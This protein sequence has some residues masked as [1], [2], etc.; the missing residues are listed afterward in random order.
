[1]EDKHRRLLDD[2][3][4][5]LGVERAM[6]PNTVSAYCSDVQSFLCSPFASDLAALGCDELTGYLAS[7]SEFLSKR[8]QARLLSSL[9]SFFD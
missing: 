1:M 5:Y 7:C 6:S 9:T 2:Y 3:A 8:S 4:Y